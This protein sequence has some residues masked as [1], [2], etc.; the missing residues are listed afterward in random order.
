MRIMGFAG[1]SGSG[2]TTTLARLIPALVADGCSVSTIKHAHHAF[3]IDAPGKDSHTHRMAGA[4]EVLVSSARRWA[5]M[6]ELRGAPQPSLADP[7]RVMQADQ[8]LVGR[9]NTRRAYNMRMRQKQNIEDTMPVAGVSPGQEGTYAHA[10]LWDRALTANEIQSIYSAS[11]GLAGA[12]AGGRI[13]NYA[14]LAGVSARVA[15]VSSFVGYCMSTLDVSQLT[16]QTTALS[17]VQATADDEFGTFFE[18]LTGIGFWGRG[19]RY[20]STAA[21]PSCGSRPRCPRR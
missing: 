2:K 18:S 6:H 11:T 7:D 12:T 14:V 3:D 8:V 5:L 15:R 1:W 10:Q 16:D 13:A 20:R 19:Y 9:N 17:A 4:T 21:G